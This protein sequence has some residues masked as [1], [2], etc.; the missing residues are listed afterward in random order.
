MA[1]LRVRLAA[2]VV[3]AASFP[4]QLSAQSLGDA[5]R[6]AEQERA[7]AR[8]DPAKVYTNS[9]LPD[10]P[11]APVVSPGSDASGTSAPASNG[12]TTRRDERPRDALDSS[13]APAS[14]GR[15]E[16]RT[17][18]SLYGDA[19]ET[20]LTLPLRRRDLNV[21]VTLVLRAVHE[22]RLPLEDAP[23]ELDANFQVESLFLG[24]VSFDRPHLVIAVGDPAD[25][26]VFTGS[27]N[28]QQTLYGVSV[29]SFPIGLATLSRLE[30]ASRIVARAHDH[31]LVE[32]VGAPDVD[33]EPVDRMLV[34]A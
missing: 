3:L 12:S 33:E 23:I 29:L 20:T 34:R 25:Q 26:V 1:M 7:K 22:K 13:P 5:A 24:K 10:A 15:I 4:L 16:A 30:S 9:D 8:Q 14:E 21:S 6:R 32:Q 31:E 28:E 17:I 19:T 11:A 2:C 27:V 18:G